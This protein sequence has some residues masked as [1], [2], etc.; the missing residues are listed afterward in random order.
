[1]VIPLFV[2]IY[3][4]LE[5]LKGK[6]NN[7]STAIKNIY[8][9]GKKC[10]Q[11]SEE[12]QE[13]CESEINNFGKYAFGV[14][15][16][17]KSRIEREKHGD[18]IILENMVK[19][20]KGELRLLIN[21]KKDIFDKESRNNL[22]QKLDEMEFTRK[23]DYDDIS[24]VLLME[25]CYK[26]I[27]ISES[28]S[29]EKVLINIESLSEMNHTKGSCGYNIFKHGDYLDDFVSFNA[30]Y[31][32]FNNVFTTSSN[33][34]V[35]PWF[36][37]YFPHALNYGSIGFIIG[38][39]ILH[40]FDNHDYKYIFGLDG[41]GELILTPESIENFEKK[42]ECFVKQYGD[43]RESITKKNINGTLTLVENIPDNG[44]LK[45]VHRAYM[46]YLQSIGGEE[47]KVPGF[48][49]FTSEQLFFI[50]NGRTF[51]EHKSKGYLEYQINNDSHTPADIRTNLALSNYK[52][53]SNA[54]NC[55]LHSGMNPGNKCEV[56]KKE[57]QN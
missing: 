4:F 25:T 17:K 42:V 26:D 5:A 36:N 8:N 41:E 37:R 55:K 12:K 18:Y 44:G 30:F 31:H 1:M 11:L 22:L 23:F 16:I 47:T 14:L 21:E 33:A 28:D 13:N 20:I 10:I 15:F 50:S 27:G 40:A 35:E 48:E 29:I 54:F 7:E 3:F 9:L 53:F 39:E 24:S 2:F 49:N 32:S 56:W 43:Q 52:P 51:C 6:Y 46:K 34:L 38:H 19:R 45:I 57:K